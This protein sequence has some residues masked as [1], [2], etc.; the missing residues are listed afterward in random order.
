MPLMF[1]I[2]VLALLLLAI[3]IKVFRQDQLREER[4]LI[5][6]GPNT[7]WKLLDDKQSERTSIPADGE[8]WCVMVDAHD[9]LN[10]Y[11]P[12]NGSCDDE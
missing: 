9:V 8:P 12:R 7:V 10:Y 2:G 4:G 5:Y 6:Q 3:A 1:I 11:R